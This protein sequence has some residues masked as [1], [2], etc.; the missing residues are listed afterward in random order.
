MTVMMRE[1]QAADRWMRRHLLALRGL[2]AG[3]IRALLRRAL[4]YRDRRGHGEELKGRTVA[5]LFFEDSTRT[6]LSFTLAARRLGA[7]VIDLGAGASS[8]SKGESIGETARV[9]EA[10]G[11][12][13]LVVRA[14]PAGAPALVAERVACSVL[15]A[16]DGR[17]EHPT[18][19]LLDAFTLANAAGRSPGFDLTGLTVLIVGDVVSSRVARSNIACLGTL[20]ARVVCIGPPAVAPPSLAS[21]GCEV[22]HDLD[23]NLP[24][25]DAVMMLRVQFERHEAG[26][27]GTTR[28]FRE[29]CALTRERAARLKPGAFILHPGPINMGL[30]MDAEVV[31]D[32]RSLVLR[33][34]AAGPPVRMAAL[35]LCLR[36]G[37]A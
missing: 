36:A 4:E 18:Q 17:H 3:E 24:R 5:T 12:D 28:E 9:V 11:V 30:E 29:A 14:K 10:M 37:S 34:V 35:E 7:E 32:P 25:A 19:G 8:I 2:E 6:R 23:A 22:A 15:S 1:R 31:D 13:A 27:I 20:G 26:A 16:G 33:Q 21:L